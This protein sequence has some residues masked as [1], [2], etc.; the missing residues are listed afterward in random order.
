MITREE[1]TKWL[2]SSKERDLLE[3]D[4][5][6]K[7]YH[8]KANGRRRKSRIINLNQEEGLIEGQENLKLYTKNF[9][10]RLFW[11]TSSYL[12]SFRHCWCRFDI[13]GGQNF[14]N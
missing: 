7:Y 9:Y 11:E 8:M 2:Q 12:D 14:P 3:G 13:C 10:K 5:N 1:E 6:S 4:S